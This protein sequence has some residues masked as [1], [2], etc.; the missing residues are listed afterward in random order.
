MHQKVNYFRMV[1]EW[2]QRI[3]FNKSCINCGK[4]I[5]CRGKIRITSLKY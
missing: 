5:K 3:Q 4:Q 1:T 2:K